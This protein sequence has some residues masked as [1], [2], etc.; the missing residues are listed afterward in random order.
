MAKTL[1]VR[2]ALIDVNPG[3]L[4][5]RILRED[6][7]KKL[8]GIGEDERLE[9]SKMPSNYEVKL[10][11]EEVLNQSELVTVNDEF[12]ERLKYNGWED[13]DYKYEDT[14]ETKWDLDK[15][16]T[17]VSHGK[18][19]EL[20]YHPLAHGGGD[21]VQGVLIRNYAA[22]NVEYDLDVLARPIGAPPEEHA[23]NV[24]AFGSIPLHLVQLEEDI[25]YPVFVNL[26]HGNRVVATLQV[27]FRKGELPGFWR[28]FWDG[29]ISRDGE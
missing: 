5:E 15:A 3:F 14:G 19:I 12:Y 27:S 22:C 4:C 8:F 20:I 1:D 28:G 13:Y 11:K 2:Y 17:R 25:G 6:E 23:I 18:E 10:L 24:S 7:V 29:F 21:L 9:S 16:A 26:K